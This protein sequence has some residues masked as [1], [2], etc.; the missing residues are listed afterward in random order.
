MKKALFKLFATVS[1]FTLFAIANAQTNYPDRPIRIILPGAVATGTDIATRVLAEQLSSRL[2]QSV[3]VDNRPGAA[4]NLGARAAA[5]ASNDGY[6]LFMG[7]IATLAMNE[8]LYPDLGYD[9]EKDFEPIFFTGSIPMLIAVHPSAPYKNLTDLLEAARAKPDQ[10]EIAIPSTTARVTSEFLQQQTGV[11]FFAVPYNTTAAGI[12]GVLGGQAVVIIDT[13]AGMRSL[14]LSGKLRALGV[15]S[16]KT[17]EL[18]PGVPSVMEQGV[19]DFEVTAWNVLAIPRG[20]TSV[21]KEKLL[22]AVQQTLR[23]PGFRARLLQAGFE[24]T[25]PEGLGRAPQDYIRSERE[26]WGSLIKSKAIKP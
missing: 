3:V 11:K 12:N 7:T 20:A 10:V 22:V 14:V 15:T 26:R 13:V 25:P 8:H 18:L 24:P 9:P 4:G 5:R 17:S 1:V 16:A 2:G 23:D 21:V 6:S 19:K